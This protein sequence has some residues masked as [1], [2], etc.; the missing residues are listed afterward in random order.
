MSILPFDDVD[1]AIDVANG[2][3]YGL[4]GAV[5]TQNLSTALGVVQGA[6]AGTTCVNCYGYIGPF[7]G[8]SGAKPS[9]YSSNGSAARMETHLYTK[10]GYIQP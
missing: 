1:E 10:S 2:G 9:E 6:H 3:E 7:F 4:G 5:W 8:F